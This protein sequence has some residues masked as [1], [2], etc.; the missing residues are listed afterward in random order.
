MTGIK[1][2]SRVKRTRKQ[3]QINYDRISGIYDLI[4]GVWEKKFR[5]IGLQKLNPV[6]GQRILQI[7][8][9]TGHDQFIISKS[10]GK[11]GTAVGVDISLRMLLKTKSRLR[12]IYPNTIL[13]KGDALLLPFK[14]NVFDSVYMSF[15]LELF[16]TPEIPVVL[17][18]CKRVL[19]NN[20]K[21]IAI[22]LSN[23]DETIM[24][25][26]YMWG[27]E[28][29]PSLLDC[30]PINTAALLFDNKF[31][32]IESQVMS[33]MGIPVEIVLASK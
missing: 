15:V 13:T 3:A 21:L 20:G 28:K 4:E 32:I 11:E 31:H 14:D 5:K 7:G 27:H 16:D 10:I 25:K 12:K 1:E 26:L 23:E 6:K 18:E 19:K 9:G 2:I 30:R 33:M 24:E 8:V 22:T 17:N 29:F